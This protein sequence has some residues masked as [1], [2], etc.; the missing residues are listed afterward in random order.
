MA[1]RNKL[2][3]KAHQ[4]LM[5]EGANKEEARALI[6]EH[7]KETSRKAKGSKGSKGGS[8]GGGRCGRAGG[9]GGKVPPIILIDDL[10]E[11]I[12]FY[13]IQCRLMFYFIIF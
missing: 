8:E 6:K 3:R 4:L 2:F 1:D 10:C 13:L 12:I 11:G 7:L 5:R 9:Q